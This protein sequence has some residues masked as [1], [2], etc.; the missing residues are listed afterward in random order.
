MAMTIHC[1]I[2]SAEEEIFSGLVELLVATGSEG[3]GGGADEGGEELA[4]HD[5][6]SLSGPHHVQ[7]L[8][9]SGGFGRHRPSDAPS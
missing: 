7:P 5:D 4:I 9:L 8:V 2:A 3:E 6:S 1:D